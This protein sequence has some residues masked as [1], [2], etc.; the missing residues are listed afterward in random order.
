MFDW[1]PSWEQ[2]ETI[3]KVAPIAT[4]IIAL[5]AAGTA[6]AAIL[7]QRDIA[8][9][10][11]AIDFFLKTELDHATIDLYDRFKKIDVSILRS[12]PMLTK[13]TLQD[14][15]DARTFL[16]ICELIAVGVNNGAFSESVSKAYW[17]DVLPNAY[18]KMEA[19]IRDVRA[20]N[21]EGGP[22]TYVDLEE[23]SR[24]WSPPEYVARRTPPQ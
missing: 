22:F 12:T 14:Y 4:A 20:S 8:K 5:G 1:W 13:L 6:V 18:G 19:F 23:L 11:A 2:W 16:N 24:K 15:K 3:G 21:D 10:R 17:G 9:R 7:I